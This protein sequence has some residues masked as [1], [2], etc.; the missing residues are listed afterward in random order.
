QDQGTMVTGLLED[1]IDA[2]RFRMEALEIRP[3]PCDI[4]SLLTA[5]LALVPPD[6]RERVDV[7][8]PPVEVG[9]WDPRRVE[10]LLTNLIGNA[11]KYSPDDSRVTVEVV[12]QE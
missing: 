2:S 5:V 6:Q 8:V 1:L 10:Q 11:L 7:T 3:A 12:R 4:G 9:H